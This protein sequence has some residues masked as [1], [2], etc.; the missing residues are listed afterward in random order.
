[1]AG[2]IVILGIAAVWD[3]RKGLEDFIK[4]SEMLSDD[5]QIVLIGL[6]KIQIVWKNCIFS[7]LLLIIL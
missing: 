7:I 3:Y 6:S 1:M 5:C 4:L 2:K